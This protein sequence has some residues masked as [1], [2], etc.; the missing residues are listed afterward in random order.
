MIKVIK[1]I[2]AGRYM[3]YRSAFCYADLLLPGWAGELCYFHR[4]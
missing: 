4:R 1:F 3:Q 2:L